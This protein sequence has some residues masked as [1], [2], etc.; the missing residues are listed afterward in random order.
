MNQLQA[1]GDAIVRCVHGQECGGCPLID[2]RYGAQLEKKRAKV[3]A[4]LSLFARELRVEVEPCVGV[5]AGEIEAYRTR[6]KFAVG[7]GGAIGMYRA[8]H[9]VVDVPECRVVSL[10]MREALSRLRAR[11]RTSE[12]RSPAFIPA[13]SGGAL[14]AVDLRSVREPPPKGRPP[15]ESLMVTLVLERGRVTDDQARAACEWLVTERIAKSAAVSWHSGQSPQL[16]GQ[17]PVVLAGQPSL[18]DEAGVGDLWLHASPGAFAQAHR[19]T[20]AN[21]HQLVRDALRER[22]V[23][24]ADVAPEKRPSVLELYAGSGALGL[25]LA[26][27]GWNVTLVESFAPATEAAREAAKLQRLKSVRVFEED[28]AKFARGAVARRARTRSAKAP[29]GVVVINPPRRGVDRAALEAICALEPSAVVYVSCD[30]ETLAR[31]LATLATGGLFARWAK[32]FDMIPLTEQVETVVLLG[33]GR[34][35]DEPSSLIVHYED[36][37]LAVIEGGAGVRARALAWAKDTK[38]WSSAVAIG[39]AT[40]DESGLVVL[41]STESE[42]HRMSRARALGAVQ[43][44]AWVK[45]VPHGKGT[46]DRPTKAGDALVRYERAEVLGGHARIALS[47][48]RGSTLAVR[49]QLASIEHPVLGDDS[50]GQ[51]G[52]NLFARE[53]LA[54]DRTALH[55]REIEIEID[56]TKRTFCAGA[57]GDL[58]LLRARLARR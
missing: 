45:S 55:V 7:A 19:Q 16:L 22:F 10:A 40:G 3:R 27:D 20:A 50:F 42:G 38:R 6:A 53:V 57:R 54:L 52:T 17:T 48:E 46:L 43:C 26:R 15:R 25:S 44:D 41:A 11:M 39:G 33:R 9:V 24:G 30:P 36:T 49:A 13:V 4:A 8:E 58:A 35:P 28:A 37:R 51:R 12:E 47:I 32:P 23:A 31:D 18:R 1:D 5:G 29:F 21:I 2:L 34:G 56:G 14:R